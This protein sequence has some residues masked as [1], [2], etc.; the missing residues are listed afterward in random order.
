MLADV[1][2]RLGHQEIDGCLGFGGVPA[3]GAS[4]VT[5]RG[6]LAARASSAAPSPPLVKTVG[7]RPAAKSR[8]S[9]SPCLA[10]SMA[11][12]KFPASGCRVAVHP[13]VRQ[14]EVDQGCDEPLLGAVVNV[15]L[16]APTSLVSGGDD[17]RPGGDE[18]GAGIGISDAYSCQLG[19]AGHA[20]ARLWRAE[21]G[22][23]QRR[24]CPTPRRRPGP[25]S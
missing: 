7:C 15:T 20:F 8:S 18:L 17:P 16:E 12:R 10:D 25:T 5:G 22:P 21:G 14:L 6:L 3:T 19:Q 13:L 4:T 23:P 1:R 9:L 24:C 11:A 2:Q